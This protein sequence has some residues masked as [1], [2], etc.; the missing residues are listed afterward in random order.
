MS[1]IERLFGTAQSSRTRGRGM[2]SLSGT[3]TAAGVSVQPESA[4]QIAAVYSCIRLLS[5]D[6]GSLPVHLYRRSDSG[7]IEADDH[8]L[9]P[10]LTD[11]PNPVIDSGELWRSVMGWMLLRGNA[12]VYVERNRDG[13]P[14]GLW[15]IAAT[16]VTLARADDGQLVY[17]VR[18]NDA[19]FAPI[20]ERGNGPDK[21]PRVRAE[22]MLHYRA[23]GLGVEGLSPIAMARQ[24][25]GVSYAAMQYVG[26][27]FAR[28][29]SPGSY[30]KVPDELSDVQYERLSR[31]W[32]DLHEGYANSH[33]LALLEGGAEW[34]S[35]GL[36]PVDA[37]FLDTY[38]LARTDIA[39]IYGV[40]PHKIGD[41]DRA[42][43]ANIEQ[44]SLDYVTNS[45]RIWL[46]RLEKVTARLRGTDRK[47]YMRFNVDALLRGDI[48]SRY[49]AYGVAR[50]WGWMNPNE[51]RR[52][53]DFEPVDGLDDY[54]QP[55]NM[56]IAGADAEPAEPTEPAEPEP[57]QPPPPTGA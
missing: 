35:V 50:Q 3:S 46:V 54:L 34:A 56:T 1:L 20:R 7:R 11:Q 55:S 41:L 52:L 16:S 30:I 48:K 57:P 43:F 26:G 27:F 40:P 38:K 8:P 14:R 42:T 9:Y 19:E 53:E 13:T 21:A 25:V 47:L 32:L 23:F 49:A 17:E 15:P 22:N 51:V 10:L 44:Q 24:Q 2:G 36:S 5:E 28:D 18:L 31:Q 37:A 33:R 6:T 12:Y 45:L 39:G 29:A 4:L